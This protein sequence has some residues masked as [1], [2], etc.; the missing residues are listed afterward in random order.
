MAYNHAV[1]REQDLKAATAT[2]K[3]LG[4]T[5]QERDAKAKLPFEKDLIH[6]LDILYGPG[7]KDE[8]DQKYSEYMNQVYK[9]YPDNLEALSFYALSILGT[10]QP[11][12][13]SF[14][15]QMKAAGIIDS[16]LG[17]YPTEQILDHPGILHYYIHALDDPLHAILALKA[18]DRYAKIAPDSSH[19]LHMPS[20]IY[21]QLGLWDKTR[22]SNRISYDASIKWVNAR[23][24]NLVDRQYHSLYWL[25]YAN[26]QHGRYA[27]AK[28]NVSEMIDIYK[29]D[30]ECSIE[31]YWALIIARYMVETQDCSYPIALEDIKKIKE[32]YI[33][34][35]VQIHSLIYAMANCAILKNDLSNAMLAIS[36]LK[37][38]REGL[39]KI[40]SQN[41]SPHVEQN[42][43]YRITLLTISIDQLLA[44]IENKKG[45]TQ[46]ALKLLDQ[47]V[48]L[49]S[50]LA[51]PSGIPLLVQSSY[52]LYG[53]LL[54]QDK[55]WKKAAEIFL[56]SFDRIPNRAA[57]YLGLALA[58][59]GQGNQTAAKQYANK[60]LFIWKDA[61]SSFPELKEAKRLSDH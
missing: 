55:Q 19:A 31:G 43:Q 18:A 34:D 41:P 17:Y 5:P 47:A 56:Q 33:S 51:L 53:N 58:M 39:E 48:K 16:A 57:S 60:A 37:E 21:L 6:S 35:E 20:H 59:E 1:W 14:R 22:D 36:F 52:N 26:L 50:S 25:M 54:L 28:Q 10:I 8:R 12:D 32:C 23:T 42:N 7:D 24:K 30:P 3:K 46:E 4:E 27:E 2:L 13:S 61:D 38:L 29:I 45:N 49:E 9:K 44:L 15:K 40:S 11:N